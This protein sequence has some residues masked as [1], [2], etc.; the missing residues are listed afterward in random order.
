V[1]FS[2]FDRVQDGN[3]FFVRYTNAQGSP[4][5][6]NSGNLGVM[7]FDGRFRKQ[8]EPW[9]NRGDIFL[10]LTGA[11]PE[12]ENPVQGY[13]GG[14]LTKMEG[15]AIPPSLPQDHPSRRVVEQ[16]KQE[17][18]DG[19]PGLTFLFMLYQANGNLRVL[20]ELESIRGT[21]CHVVEMEDL[22]PKSCTR[23]W[24][25]HDKGML[26]VKHIWE[27]EGGNY[28]RM[29][30]LE[31]ASVSTSRG[32]F[33]YP[34]IATREFKHDAD[35]VKYEL[36]VDEF[37]PH[38][39]VAPETFDVDFPDGTKVL[40][41]VRYKSST[42]DKDKDKAYVL[43]EREGQ[44]R[45]HGSFIWDKAK[46][47]IFDERE[48]EFHQVP[49]GWTIEVKEGMPLPALT[50]LE[51]NTLVGQITGKAVLICFFDWQQRPSRNCLLQ[52]AEKKGALEKKGIAVI[53]VQAAKAERDKLDQWANEQGIDLPIG[54][55][56][57]DVEKELFRWGV[58]SL[59]WLILADREHIVQAE[60]FAVNESERFV[61]GKIRR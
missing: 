24:F 26:P 22:K 36:K 14:L 40:Y 29:E 1:E 12:F 9:S 28:S 20:P 33:W 32:R 39:E 2:Y 43:D 45:G 60:G 18:P 31:V 55:F 58:R 38:I 30:F 3:C 46:T 13:M 4:A 16:F 34:K 11:M 42:Q 27:D 5:D 10:G 59:P 56:A 17:Y 50:G 52:L 41:F 51:P 54:M 23:Y 37:I 19:V 44:F 35:V 6:V 49:K 15:I 61:L 48:G 57:A 21:W 7:S 47:L 8:Y 53:A 25:A